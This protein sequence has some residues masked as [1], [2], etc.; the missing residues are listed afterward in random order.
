MK[1]KMNEK[2]TSQVGANTFEQYITYIGLHKK[3]IFLW[4]NDPFCI[5]IIAYSR[6]VGSCLSRTLFKSTIINMQQRKNKKKNNLLLD[7]FC[8]KQQYSVLWMLMVPKYM[9]AIQ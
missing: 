2:T 3:D 7:N 4:T 9:L 5:W 8:I 6:W 1:Q